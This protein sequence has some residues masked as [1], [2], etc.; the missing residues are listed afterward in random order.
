MRRTSLVL[1]LLT[2]LLPGARAAAQTGTPDGGPDP[3]SIR[4]R[5]GPVWMNPRLELTNLG[6]D[7]NVFNEPPSANPKK[8]FTAT[9]TPATDLWLRMGRSWLQ[10][11]IRED[12]VWYQKYSSE[13]S[14]NNSYRL[15]WKMRLNR[16]AVALT[17]DYLHTRDRPGFEIDARSRRTEYGGKADIEVRTLSKTFVALTGS[18][19]RVDFDKEAV[20][21]DKNLQ[22]ELDRTTTEAG[23]SLRHQL[24]PLTAIALNVGRSQD[25]FEFSSLRDS[26]STAV[27]TSV[28]FD[29]HALLKGG[30]SF[31]FRDFEPL[32]PGVP[33]YRG[34]TTTGDLAYALLG[35]TRFA[36][37]FKR[38]VSYSFDV[39]Q[40]YYLESGVG[41][42]VAQQIFGP[43]DAVAR[44]GASRL[45]Y[46]DRANALVEVVDRVD[47]IR[48]YGVG[49]GYRLGREL[50]IGFNV[51][52]QHRISDVASRQYDGLKYGTSVTYG[53]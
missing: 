37:Q 39:N 21:L 4:V 51:D 3:S 6:V 8:D 38:D 29:P 16:L 9:V 12:L 47:Y 23:V 44:V 25:R 46:R 13:R 27:S 45:A 28:T 48:S 42:S 20:F 33:N 49:A 19:R 24:T 31:G 10:M 32:S 26:N 53:F 2:A 7:T 1:L 43:V 11:N 17:P 41:A 22:N 40:P 52:K 50:R 34:I 35:T 5:I 30:A 15:S 18:W 14:A 36:V